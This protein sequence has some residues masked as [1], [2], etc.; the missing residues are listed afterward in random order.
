[1]IEFASAEAVFGSVARGD[2]DTLS[3]KDVVIVDDDCQVLGRRRVVLEQAGWSVASYTFKKLSLMAKKGALF[4]Q[5]LKAESRIEIDRTGRF[6]AT[7]DAFRPKSTY[8]AELKD[9]AA[10]ARLAVIWPNSNSG[11]MWAADVMYGAVRNFGILYLAQKGRYVFS[12]AGVLEGLVDEG[13]LNHATITNLLRL[14]AAKVIY[15][16]GEH[17]CSDDSGALLKSVLIGL[18]GT[19]FPTS[20]IPV[21][22]ERILSETTTLPR[23]CSGYHRLRRLERSFIALTAIDHRAAASEEFQQLIRWIE[24]PR[25]YT[26]A[27][28]LRE[29]ELMKAMRTHSKQ[30]D[31]GLFAHLS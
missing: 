27:A 24:D 30:R 20:S 11:G 4:I 10:L 16:A 28:V 8:A 3:D 1:V 14:R 18:P 31:L 2:G 26:G 9:N 21:A 29:Q 12:Y 22:P 19:Y 15:R 23:R 6:R 17:W 7:L 13:V 5:H 25:A